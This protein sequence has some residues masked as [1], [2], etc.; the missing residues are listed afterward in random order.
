MESS[1]GSGLGPVHVSGGC[2]GSYCQVVRAVGDVEGSKEST[3]RRK[4]QGSR[5]GHSLSACPYQ[6]AFKSVL[7]DRAEDK[8]LGLSF[9]QK[10]REDILGCD[11]RVSSFRS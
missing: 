8:L 9:K 7:F 5:V 6:M 4:S 2:Q 3:E 1:P 11:G 10:L